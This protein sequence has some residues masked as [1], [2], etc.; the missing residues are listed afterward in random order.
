MTGHSA[1]KHD[2][3]LP[4]KYP[5]HRQYSSTDIQHPQESRRNPQKWNMTMGH[6]EVKMKKP[7][8]LKYKWWN[9]SCLSAIQSRVPTYFCFLIL[10]YRTIPLQKMNLSKT[11]KINAR[12]IDIKTEIEKWVP[13]YVFKSKESSHEKYYFISQQK[14]KKHL[15]CIL[16]CGGCQ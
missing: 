13:I 14:D 7:Q 10:L 16:T 12:L 11:V 8:L 3:S 2:L 1:I 15:Y 6:S 5:V 4:D 9:Y